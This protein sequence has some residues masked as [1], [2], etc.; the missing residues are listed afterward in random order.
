MQVANEA[1]EREQCPEGTYN[2]VC[3]GIVDLGTQT[4]TFNGK[5]KEARK[6]SFTFEIQGE[7]DSEGNPFY[8]YRKYTMSLAPKSSFAKDLKTWMNKTV[9]K[10]ES[11][12]IDT[13]LGKPCLI[14]ITHNEGDGGAVYA[15]ISG[16]A[17]PMK[18]TKVAKPKAELLSFYMDGDRL[19]TATF[20]QLP[21]YIQGVIAESPEFK[22]LASKR[23]GAPTPKAPVAKAG[24][25]KGR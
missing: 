9:A 22:A 17:A 15:N 21:Q 11:F 1:K 24:S 8:V 12:E 14:T 19:D 2:A 25:K 4:S 3:V 20:D 13:L 23:K 16:I 5:T 10:G 18:G 6:V 7:E